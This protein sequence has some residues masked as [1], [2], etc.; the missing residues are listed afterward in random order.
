MNWPWISRKKHDSIVRQCKIDVS[1]EWRSALYDREEELRPLQAALATMRTHSVVRTFT[2]DEVPYVEVNNARPY[3]RQPGRVLLVDMPSYAWS[4]YLN[5]LM[6]LCK[7]D[8]A[9]HVAADFARGWDKVRDE[10]IQRVREAVKK[11]LDCG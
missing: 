6:M 9:D 2:R 7:G 4:S 3:D 10:A 1:N 11:E 8:P 5:P